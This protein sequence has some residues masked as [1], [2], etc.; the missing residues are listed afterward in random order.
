[1]HYS[2]KDIE[3]LTGVKAHTLRIW[4]KRYNLL[5]PTRTD[6]N[7][8]YYSD[9]DLKKLLNI[10]TL[11]KSG[12]KISK[13]AELSQEVIFKKVIDLTESARDVRVFLEGLTIA[14]VEV[15]EE[16]FEKVLNSA[17]L[18]FGFEDTMVSIIYPFFKRIGV[19]WLTGTV[20][21]GQEH[22]ISNLLR[23]KLIVAIDGQFEPLKRE[24][25][26]FLLYLPEGELHELGLLFYSYLIKSKGHKVIYL[27]QSVPLDD[28]IQIAERNS[29]D[30]LMSAFLSFGN[31]DDL[32]KYLNT[33]SAK[34]NHV[35]K[36]FVVDNSLI[37]DVSVLPKNFMQV[38]DYK[39]FKN[40]L[41]LLEHQK[42]A[43]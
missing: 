18:K 33:L 7:I 1:M 31:L 30:Y 35:K 27:G 11:N 9:N 15:D 2:I 24:H 25:K 4:E 28:V 43:N 41:D 29:I 32:L 5:E 22:F 10:V 42:S 26:K 14:M 38:K 34:I 8:R 13:I 39:D 23:Q 6:T 12:Y 16:R 20:S 19:M 36:F 37:K 3:R 40:F 17:I 21:P